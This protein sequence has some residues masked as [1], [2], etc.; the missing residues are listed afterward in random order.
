MAIKG[1]NNRFISQE[2]E[3]LDR[4]GVNCKPFC[5]KV[6]MKCGTTACDLLADL[7]KQVRE[8]PKGGK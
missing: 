8:N 4:N 6:G 7:I 2:A 3:C 1:N 5:K